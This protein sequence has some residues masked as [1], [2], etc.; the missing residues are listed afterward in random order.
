M[1]YTTY[2]EAKYMAV[3]RANRTGVSVLI[4]HSL[5]GEPGMH[6]YGVAYTLP[7]HSVRIGERIYP[8]SEAERT[9]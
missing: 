8:S 7:M 1:T 6:E 5:L 9:Q 4:Y 2:T 3:R